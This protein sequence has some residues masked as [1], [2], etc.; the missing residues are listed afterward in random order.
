MKDVGIVHGSREQA[1]PLVVGA[2]TVY[3]HTDIEEVTTTDELTGEAR[4][5]FKYHEIQYGKDEYIRLM[6]EQT[7][8]NNRLMNLILGVK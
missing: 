1:V 2:D 7:D 5:D 6:A 3:I 4:T 8:E